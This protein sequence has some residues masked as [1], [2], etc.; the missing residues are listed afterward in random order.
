MKSSHI[1]AAVALS[2]VGLTHAQQDAQASR[3]A[4]RAAAPVDAEVR[5]IDREQNKVT[6]RH[7]PIPSLDMPAMTMVFRVSDPK[8]LESLKVGDK[9][10]FAADKIDGAYTVTALEIVR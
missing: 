4:Q 3:P 2:F 1:I 6:L 5:K 9:V 7:A 10:K 8:V